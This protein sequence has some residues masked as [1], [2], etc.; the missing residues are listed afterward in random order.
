MP[1]LPTRK[2]S[3][4]TLATNLLAGDTLPFLRRALDEPSAAQRNQR[5]GLQTLATTIKPM[6]ALNPNTTAGADKRVRFE[7]DAQAAADPGGGDS[8]EGLSNDVLCLGMLAWVEFHTTGYG[9]TLRLVYDD[10]PRVP[11]T[12]GLRAFRTGHCVPGDVLNVRWVIADSA[13][14]IAANVPAYDATFNAT[15]TPAGYPLGYVVRYTLSGSEGFYKAVDTGLLPAPT[16]PVADANWERVGAP[17][18][19]A[20]AF[21]RLSLAE[22]QALAGDEVIVPGRLYCIDFAGSIGEV[23][24]EGHDN[25]RFAGAGFVAHPTDVHRTIPVTVDVLV[26]TAVAPYITEGSA[27]AGSGNMLIQVPGGDNDIYTGSNNY[28][29]ATNGGGNTIGEGATPGIVNGCGIETQGDSN[30]IGDSA[31]ASV[32]RCAIRGGGGPNIIGGGASI[33]VADCS[34]IDSDNCLIGD[35]CSRVTLINCSGLV[36]PDGTTNTTYINNAAI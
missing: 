23:W 32:L 5:V 17:V 4:D 7:T 27:P 35:A 34:I 25:T 2:L 19:A 14:A 31:T 30:R 29:R 3:A 12:S 22:A 13:E 16:D 9:V 33:G 8:L 11:A 26:G 21:Q 24:A 18:A 28:L 10:V 6:L 36:V 20:A 1:T 15:G